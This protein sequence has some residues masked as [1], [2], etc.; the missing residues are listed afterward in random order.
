VA[1]VYTVARGT[2][3]ESISALRVSLD[4]ARM[5]AKEKLDG[6]RRPKMFA[7]TIESASSRAARIEKVLGDES[8][9]RISPEFHEK[10]MGMKACPYILPYNF[11]TISSRRSHLQRN[12]I[13]KMSQRNNDIG[14]TSFRS[15]IPKKEEYAI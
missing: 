5:G 4:A 1:A 8:K 15:A 11:L 12:T 10:C 3:D 9:P 14:I 13:I 6:L 7:R 2:H